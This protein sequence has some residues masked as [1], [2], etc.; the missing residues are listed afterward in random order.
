MTNLN[1]YAPN[2]KAS[3]YMKQ[4]SREM[5]GKTQKPTTPLE[6]LILFSQ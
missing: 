2:K 5:K 6:A 4:N 3:K 1:V